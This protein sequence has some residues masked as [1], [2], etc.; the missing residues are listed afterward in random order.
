MHSEVEQDLKSLEAVKIIGADHVFEVI[1]RGGMPPYHLFTQR[2]RETAAVH[3]TVI[4][5]WRTSDDKTSVM[6]I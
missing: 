3:F 2:D 4:R 5:T 6:R 1:R